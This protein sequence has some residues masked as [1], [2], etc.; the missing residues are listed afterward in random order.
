MYSVTVFRLSTI[1]ENRR[2][3][4]EES[5]FFLLHPPRNGI[6]CADDCAL[7]QPLGHSNVHFEG[8]SNL[9]VPQ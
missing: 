2:I 1:L 4:Q 7:R 3:P 8:L 6:C 9:Y 5:R